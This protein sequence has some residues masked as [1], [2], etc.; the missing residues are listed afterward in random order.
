MCSKDSS[1]S[2][3]EF[4][5]LSVILASAF[6][7]WEDLLAIFSY[8]SKRSETQFRPLRLEEEQVY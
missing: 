7:N 1:L 5:M 4:S 3:F 8:N 6:F 2:V